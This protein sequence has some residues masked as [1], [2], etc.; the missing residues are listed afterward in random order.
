MSALLVTGFGPFLDVVDNPSA[1]LVRALDGAALGP[2]LTVVG[3]VLP[4]SYRRAVTE[5]LALIDAHAPIAVV[6]VG[7]ARGREG[8]WIERWGRRWANPA[9]A[10]IDG[11]H[12]DDLDPGGPAQIESTAPVGDLAAALG[13][14]VSEDA[15]GYVCNAW[16]YG[17]LR[18][19]QPRVPVGSPPAIFVHLPAEGIA[20][21]LFSAALVQVWRPQFP[22]TS[23]MDPTRSSALKS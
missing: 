15:G 3:R 13:A 14:L 20:P 23:P 4:V 17:V 18:A 10:D 12:A 22:R 2:D 8:V 16:L 6:G 19:L 11:E 9:L 1:R 5:T 21:E 7:V